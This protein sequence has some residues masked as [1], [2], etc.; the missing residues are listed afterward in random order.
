[1]IDLQM[2]GSFPTPQGTKG[3]HANIDCGSSTFNTSKSKITGDEVENVDDRDPKKGRV[4]RSDVW[5]HFIRVGIVDGVEKCQCKY[6]DKLYSCK[7]KSGTTSLKRRLEACIEFP[8]S[9]DVKE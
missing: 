5:K 3:T 9:E 2:L 4:D 1:M 6:C 8:K 7:A